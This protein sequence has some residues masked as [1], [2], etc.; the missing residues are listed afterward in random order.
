MAHETSHSTNLH[1]FWM[2]NDADG[3]QAHASFLC[4]KWKNYEKMAEK[5]VKNASF[6]I[7]WASFTSCANLLHAT[8]QNAGC[9]GIMSPFT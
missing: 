6:S 7:F 9:R 5:S 8:L 4:I 1:Y 3:L 2:P